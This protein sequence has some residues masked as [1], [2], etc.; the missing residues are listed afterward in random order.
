MPTDGL[1]GPI[2]GSQACYWRTPPPSK[3]GVRLLSDHPTQA[4]R[5]NRRKRHN[6][7]LILKAGWG[8][9]CWKIVQY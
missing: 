5:L 2:P 3:G 6:P 1:M 9:F 7:H 4:A 8:L